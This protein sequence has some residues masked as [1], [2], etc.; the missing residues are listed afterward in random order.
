MS[1]VGSTHNNPAVAAQEALYGL[2]SAQVGQLP[3]RAGY[4]SLWAIW[5]GSKSKLEKGVVCKALHSA[6]NRPQCGRFRAFG[7]VFLNTDFSA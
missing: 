3:Q 4:P 2:S 5:G 6:H 7:R 1:M